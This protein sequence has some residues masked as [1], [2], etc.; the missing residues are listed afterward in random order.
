MARASHCYLVIGTCG[1]NKAAFTVKHELLSFLRKHDNITLSLWDVQRIPDGGVAT[2]A[3][4]WA[5]STYL[6]ENTKT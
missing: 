3:D 1:E 4:Y 5:A 6:Q 2:V